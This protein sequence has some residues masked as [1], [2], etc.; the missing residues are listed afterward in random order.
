MK[1][2]KTLILKLSAI[3]TTLMFAPV[4][5]AASGKE[6]VNVFLGD[7]NAKL[8]ISGGLGLAAAILAVGIFEQDSDVSIK[9]KKLAGAAILVALAFKW[10]ALLGLIGLM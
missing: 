7:K 6:F 10:D 9:M 2:V 4:L 8:I 1:N 3:F 5:Y